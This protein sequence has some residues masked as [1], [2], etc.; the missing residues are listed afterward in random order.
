[1]KRRKSDSGSLTIEAA[2]MVPMFIMLM[3][4]VNGLFVMFM[5]QQIMAHTLIQSAKSLAFD[6]YS[7]QRVAAN[8][9][10]Q[11]AEMFTDL[12]A[13][14][15][16]GHVSTEPWYEDGASNVA[17]I[18]RARYIANLGESRTDVEELF[19]QIG[20]KN[21][22]AGL[23]FSGT[24]IEDGVLKMKMKYTQEFLFDALDLGEFQRE[25]SVSVKLFE[26]KG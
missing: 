8:E 11:L 26:Y 20:V 5:G 14:T 25:L 15:G 1:M 10:D 17:D 7:T 3:L 22:F 2:I 23:D 4:L 13:F 19:D 6:P 21:G 9:D 24:V 16:N 18:A 12:F